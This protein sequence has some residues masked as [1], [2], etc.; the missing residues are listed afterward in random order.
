MEYNE[1]ILFA[2]GVIT[3]IIGYFLKREAKSLQ[4]LEER[5]SKLEIVLT[6]NE[7]RDTERWKQTERL[8]EERRCD[9]RKIFDILQSDGI[10]RN[11]S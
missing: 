3:S 11:K 10:G 1:I 2:I 8:L 4:D 7:V 6:K 5:V 9:I